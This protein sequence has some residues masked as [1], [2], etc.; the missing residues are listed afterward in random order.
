M[1][2]PTH[3]TVTL[4]TLLILWLLP[5]QAQASYFH[6]VY[7]IIDYSEADATA[8]LLSRGAEADPIEGI[9]QDDN[10]H[11]YAIELNVDEDQLRTANEFRMIALQ[12]I[13]E[14]YGGWL[15]GDVRAYFYKKSDGTYTAEYY[16]IDE[17]YDLRS[18]LRTLLIESSSTLRIPQANEGKDLILRRQA[19]E[20]ASAASARAALT[21]PG[22]P[23]DE[24]TR[25]TY[26]C[27]AP[28]GDEDY[29]GDDLPILARVFL[30]P[31]MTVFLCVIEVKEGQS[32]SIDRGACLIDPKTQQRYKLINTSGCPIAPEKQY[33]PCTTLFGLSFE[34]IPATCHKIDFYEAA[35]SNWNTNPSL[36]LGDD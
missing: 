21:T 16:Y 17:N 19:W 18:R 34:P 5:P 33:G 36:K 15:Q 27:D 31:D 30:Y 9:W 23:V 12:A 28:L 2:R 20:G 22:S 29:E 14:T 13:D 35:G 3:I 1:N 25:L 26:Y 6:T 10:G 7:G 32:F 11:S 8:Y 24:D 4:T